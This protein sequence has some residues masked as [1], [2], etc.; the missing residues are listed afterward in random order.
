M[1]AQALPPLC[2]HGREQPQRSLPRRSR[3]IP[4]TPPRSVCFVLCASHHAPSP[5]S[6][7]L[8]FCVVL[9][10]LTTFRL[11]SITGWKT[12]DPTPP[13]PSKVTNI[14]RRTLLC[15]RGHRRAC[16]PC[17]KSGQIT[18]CS[19]NSSPYWLLCHLE[20]ASSTMIKTPEGRSAQQQDGFHLDRRISPATSR[21]LR[22]AP[23]K[24]IINKLRRKIGQERTSLSQ[25]S[26]FQAATR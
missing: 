18:R 5:V 2:Q 17:A 4:G 24:E 1:R 15:N 21:F 14:H 12:G 25:E 23:V 6:F 11:V 26:N 16:G 20:A 10:N 9:T 3:P 13:D 19:Q 22:C 7:T 8:S